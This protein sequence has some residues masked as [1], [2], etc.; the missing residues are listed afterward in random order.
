MSRRLLWILPFAVL[1]SAAAVA[2]PKGMR[3][4]NLTGETLDR[5]ELAPAGTQK[6]GRNQCSN[7]DDG[8]VDFDEELPIKG[9]KPGRYD[10]RVRDVHGKTCIARNVEVK[11]NASFAVHEK[12]LADCTP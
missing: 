11:A 1:A 2:A 7:D 12:D 10:V 5:V 9:V 6:W 8:T 4:W 3:L